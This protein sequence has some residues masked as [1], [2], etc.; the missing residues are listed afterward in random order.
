M[1]NCRPKKEKIVKSISHWYIPPGGS[2]YVSSPIATFDYKFWH[3]VGGDN[4]NT[5]LIENGS[6]LEK[7]YRTRLYSPRG[8]NTDGDVEY[9]WEY[10]YQQK[11][12]VKVM[13]ANDANDKELAPLEDSENEYTIL[14]YDGEG[15][16]E[17]GDPIYYNKPIFKRQC[18]ANTVYD[19]QYF[20]HVFNW[21]TSNISV[22]RAVNGIIKTSTTT[23][24][25]DPPVATTTSTYAAAPGNVTATLT[26]QGVD[27]VVENVP[28]GLIYY[29]GGTF[30]NKIFFRYQPDANSDGTLK[31]IAEG[32]TVN[33]WTIS[34]VIN[35][36]TDKAL[37]RRISKSSAKNK[38]PSYVFVNDLIDPKGKVNNV[39]NLPASYTGSIDDYYVV[40]DDQDTLNQ[41]YYQ[42]NG[43]AWVGPVNVTG[44]LVGDRVKGKGISKDTLVTQIKGRKIFLS[45]PLRTRRIRK[46]T[47]VNNVINK[48]NASTLCYAEISG[49]SADFT[50]GSY[51]TQAGCNISVVAGKGIK[52][53]SA[54]V[55]IY[56][57]RN[58]RYVEYNPIFYNRDSDCEKTYVEDSNARY[59]VGDIILEDETLYVNDTE[60]VFEPKTDITYRI[61]QI[62][63]NNFNMPVTKTELLKILD[64]YP[65]DSEYLEMEKY[66]ISIVTPTL[67]E[68][69]V[70]RVLDSVCNDPI[71]PAVEKIYYP[72]KEL[73][74]LGNSFNSLATSSFDP[75]VTSSN[76]S[77]A[78]TVEEL[79]NLINQ[80][81]TSSIASA[82]LVLPEEMYKQV[83]SNENSLLNRL[84][85][86]VNTIQDSV[87]KIQQMPNLPAMVEGENEAPIDLVIQTIRRMPPKFGNLEFLID[88]VIFDSDNSLNPNAVENNPFMTIRSIPAFTGSFSCSNPDITISTVTKTVGTIT[89]AIDYVE[90]TAAPPVQ[91][92]PLIPGL[93]PTTTKE[94]VEPGPEGTPGANEDDNKQF[95]KHKTCT[96]PRPYPKTIW[97]S[98]LSYQSKFGKTCNFRINEISNAVSDALSNKGNPYQD[99]PVYAELLEDVT[100]SSTS[101]KIKGSTANFMSSGYLL[102]PKYVMKQSESDLKNTSKHYYYLGEEII[103]YG[104]KTA[105]SFENC[106]RGQ[107][108]T[109]PTFEVI[110]PAEDIESGFLYTIQTLGDTNWADLGAPEGYGVGTTFKSTKD[111]TASTGTAY[112]FGSTLKPFDNAPPV[113]TVF[114]SYQKRNY[115]VQFWPYKLRTDTSNI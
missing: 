12:D 104:S 87:S 98:D 6:K 92:P 44:I 103:Y 31:V 82:G 20:Y 52:T 56:A 76:P 111:G 34:K 115:I 67:N 90:T 42:W 10:V 22:N 75:C 60:L 4:N 23:T 85:G 80:N 113:N 99:D 24:A 100:S 51:T 8:E 106:I 112:V 18:K 41:L 49:G 84:N 17:N 47:F 15:A 62:Y 58:K 83:I 11:Y 39:S 5:K 89:N 68:K 88:D 63:W 109:T 59:S 32:D 97:K 50:I 38:T 33:G 74:Q 105:N 101:I 43:T 64:K 25:G 3:E 54:I 37:R 96:G 7:L 55:G 108:G 73:D 40:D 45:K 70:A 16:F 35:Y 27:S 91:P 66:I 77:P 9:N 72:Y 114:H 57:A 46:A 81:L 65:D 107:F 1:S 13:D 2:A 36:V 53:R 78:F 102:L 61:N 21:P 79:Q 93:P 48:V 95:N 14:G 26:I 110:V 28:D 94:W 69:K 71:Y 86:A 29:H 30:S 19:E